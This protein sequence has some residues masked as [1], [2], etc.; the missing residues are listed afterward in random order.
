MCFVDVDEVARVLWTSLGLC[1]VLSRID[2]NVIK[3]ATW[4]VKEGGVVACL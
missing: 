4:G 2:E 3:N 1:G